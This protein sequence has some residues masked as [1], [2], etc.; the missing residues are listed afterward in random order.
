MT[1][2]AAARVHHR[3]HRPRAARLAEPQDAVRMAQDAQTAAR[4]HDMTLLSVVKDVC[5]AVGVTMPHVACSPASP[6]TAP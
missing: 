1:R 6:A 3:Q 5:A 4:W 2:R